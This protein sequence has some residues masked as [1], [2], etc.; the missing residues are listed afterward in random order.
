MLLMSFCA[1]VRMQIQLNQGWKIRNLGV[2]FG[3]QWD[4]E[5]FSR[6]EIFL[7]MTIKRNDRR[8]LETE[9]LS[10]VS[11]PRENQTYI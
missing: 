8:T 2:S 9:N 6:K 10:K 11:S 7:R 1:F 5:I 4:A 3:M